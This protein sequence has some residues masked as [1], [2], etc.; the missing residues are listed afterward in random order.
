MVRLSATTRN[1]KCYYNNPQPSRRGLQSCTTTTATT[2]ASLT[3]PIMIKGLPA[4]LP[5]A[6]HCLSHQSIIARI[7]LVIS[8]CRCTTA[9]L[10]P[11]RPCG[12]AK[13]FITEMLLTAGSSSAFKNCAALLTCAVPSGGV[14]G[15]A[16]GAAAAVVVPVPSSSPTSSNGR[17]PGSTLLL[18]ALLLLALLLAMMVYTGRLPQLP[19]LF[20]AAVCVG[21]RRAPRAW[22]VEAVC[23]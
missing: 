1:C 22:F 9:G 11:G 23:D 3:L 17:A 14:W 18:P 20:S 19:I 5:A 21:G 15:G 10:T 16:G 4:L 13:G 7:G 6:W 8:T 2:A 12:M